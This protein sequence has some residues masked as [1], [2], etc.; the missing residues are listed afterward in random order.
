MCLLGGGRTYSGP[1][2][3]EEG[4]PGRGGGKRER[5]RE[6]EGFCPVSVELEFNYNTTL[7][8]IMSKRLLKLYKTD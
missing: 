1:E 5:E 7:C 6:R 3:G 2:L 8:T 4:V